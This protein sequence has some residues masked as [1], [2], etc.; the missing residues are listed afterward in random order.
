MIDLTPPKLWG[1]EPY[2]GLDH[3]FDPLWYLT[4]EQRALQAELIAVCHDIIRP[5]AVEADKTGEYPRESL[6]ALADLRLL[7]AVVPEELGGRGLDNVGILM[8]T[9]T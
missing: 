3:E 6:K 1:G 5:L 8:A 2:Y 4:D 9:E 7:A